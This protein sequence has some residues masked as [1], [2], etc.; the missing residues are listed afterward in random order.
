MLVKRKQ[1][2]DQLRKRYQRYNEGVEMERTNNLKRMGNNS[3]S[4]ELLAV[5][6]PI[7]HERISQTFN[8]RT[9][10]FAESFD[11]ISSGGMGDV[12]WRSELDII[13]A[14]SIWRFVSKLHPSIKICIVMILARAFSFQDR[15]PSFLICYPHHLS[16][17]KYPRTLTLTIYREPRHHH[18]PTY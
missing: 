15:K 5:I 13:A 9:L 2:A 12:D 17:Q 14:Q 3:H 6:S 18:K 1:V 16:D 7:H 4:H 10:C 8:N 11:G